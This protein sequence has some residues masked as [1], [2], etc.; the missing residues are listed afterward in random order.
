M[1]EI[2]SS[3]PCGPAS[4]IEAICRLAQLKAFPTDEEIRSSGHLDAAAFLQALSI[5]NPADFESF[6]TT[7]GGSF[8]GR[9]RQPLPRSIDHLLRMIV[10]TVQGRKAK[11][12]ADTGVGGEEEE[13]A[14]IPLGPPPLPPPLAPLTEKE[15]NAFCR[16]FHKD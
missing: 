12:P 2:N 13:P 1:R 15:A 14:A 3:C 7:R 16:A 8:G 9:M 4:F 6:V 11:A 10:A 5:F